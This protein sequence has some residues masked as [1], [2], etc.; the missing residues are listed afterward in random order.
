MWPEP[1]FGTQ[2]AM[3]TFDWRWMDHGGLLMRI[4]SFY[5]WPLFVWK[6]MKGSLIFVLGFSR[7]TGPIGCIQ[8]EKEVY[9][10]ELARMMREADMSASW[11][12]RREMWFQSE[13]WQA[14]GPERL[15]VSAFLPK[16]G[17]KRM[18]QQKAVRQFFLTRGK[19]S[20]FVLFRPSTDWMR[21]THVRKSNLF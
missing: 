8:I 16:A 14:W 6:S 17:R 12:P 10:K 1:C 15:D 9:F 3:E 4:S 7:E 19:V 18:S 20:L 2:V 5:L 11:R 13:C 21:P